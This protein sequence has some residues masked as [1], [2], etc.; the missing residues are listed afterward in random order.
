MWVFAEYEATTLFSL[1]PASATASGGKTLLVPTPFAI[2]MA[3]VDALCRLEGAAV[4]QIEW[5]WLRQVTIALKPAPAVVVNNTFIKVLKPRRNPAE[6]GS[7]DAG[8]FGRT[9]TYREYAQ[10]VGAFGIAFQ[11]ETMEQAEKL[12]LLLWNIN[13]LGKRGS[14]IQAVRPPDWHDTLP[15]AYIPVTTQPSFDIRA[16]LTQ[17]D[18]VGEEVAFEYIDIY[19]DKKNIQLGKQRILHHVAL[20]YQLVSSSRGYSYYQVI[21]D[22]SL[23]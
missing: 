16:I 8:Y 22:D 19:S 4:A 3:L 20:P 15:Q 7:M 13:Y 17:L 5:K 10:L 21:T 18:D 11:V 2:K 14:F 23:S 12:A 6:P 1:K 9:I